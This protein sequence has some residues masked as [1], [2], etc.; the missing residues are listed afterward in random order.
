LAAACFTTQVFTGHRIEEGIHAIDKD[1]AAAFKAQ[2][3]KILSFAAGC[4]EWLAAV[5]G[6]RSGE[7]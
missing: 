4:R 7:G 5:G 3:T 6:G 2:R 1:E